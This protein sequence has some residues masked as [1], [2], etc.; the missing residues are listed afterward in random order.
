MFWLSVVK[1][2]SRFPFFFVVAQTT[3]KK[4]YNNN[5]Q[6][7]G[8]IQLYCMLISLQAQD[9]VRE[10]SIELR[11]DICNFKQEMM[12]CNYSGE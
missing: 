5:F 4:N 9:P 1:Y 6:I 11:K 2:I 3:K 10:D 7:D 12:V 8:V